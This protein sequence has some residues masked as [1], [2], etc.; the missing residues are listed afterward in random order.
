MLD[1]T[2]DGKMNFARM[3]ISLQRAA[4]ACLAVP[5][6]LASGLAQAQSVPEMVAQRVSASAWYVE[7]VGALG[8]AA[9]QNFISNAAFVVTPAG[10]VVIDALGSPALSMRLL[11]EVKKVTPQPVTHVLVTHYHADHIY[12]LQ[13]FQAMG[14]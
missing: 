6:G 4:L 5:F 14:A 11:E 3:L 7:G 1:K 8:S 10:V 2:S 13:T 12:G 9:N